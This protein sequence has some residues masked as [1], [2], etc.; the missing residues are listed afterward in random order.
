MWPRRSTP[1]IPPRSSGAIHLP[2]QKTGVIV[3]FK[4]YSQLKSETRPVGEPF[5][6][7]QSIDSTNNYAM[8]RVHEG[9]ARHGFAVL[10]HEQ[11]AGKGQRQKTWLAQA[12]A[13]LM[14]SVVV[15]PEPL[16]TKPHFRFSMAMAL[17][18]AS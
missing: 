2:Q 16:F 17:A 4:N 10:A 13:N 12:G 8:A 5:I 11:T 14:M 7:L 9:V 15:E 6:E 1:A 3:L 18:D